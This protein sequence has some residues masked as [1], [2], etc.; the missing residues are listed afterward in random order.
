MGN[1]AP[2][3]PLMDQAQITELLEQSSDILS[4]SN[5]DYKCLLH[6]CVPLSGF[7]PDEAYL[8]RCEA[9]GEYDIPSE[10]TDFEALELELVRRKNCFHLIVTFWLLKRRTSN[11]KRQEI[12]TELNNIL[13]PIGEF[14]SPCSV[15]PPSLLRAVKTHNLRLLSF[16]LCQIVDTFVDISKPIHFMQN[17]TDFNIRRPQLDVIENMVKLT[18][19]LATKKRR[20]ELR[21]EDDIKEDVACCFPE[22]YCRKIGNY[23]QWNLYAENPQVLWDA[24]RAREKIERLQRRSEEK[25]YEEEL[26][27]KEEAKRLAEEKEEADALSEFVKFKETNDP[28]YRERFQQDIHERGRGVEMTSDFDIKYPTVPGAIGNILVKFGAKIEPHLY[29]RPAHLVSAH[30]SCETVVLIRS[31]SHWGFVVVCGKGQV[32]LHGKGDTSLNL[33][34]AVVSFRDH[35][36]NW[37]IVENAEH[38]IV[39][40]MK[41]KRVRFRGQDIHRSIKNKK[42]VV[43]RFLDEDDDKA[44]YE[45]TMASS[46][47]SLQADDLHYNLR[48]GFDFFYKAR[49]FTGLYQHITPSSMEAPYHNAWYRDHNS[50]FYRDQGE[51]SFTQ[52]YQKCDIVDYKGAKYCLQRV[53]FQ[54][55]KATP[56]QTWTLYRN[57]EPFPDGTLQG[58]IADTNCCCIVQKDPFHWDLM[59]G[60]EGLYT[61]WRIE[62]RG[63]VRIDLDSEQVAFVA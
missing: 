34:L 39:I 43:F 18:Q 16:A 8:A 13:K 56:S 44:A 10:K 12:I 37:E 53:K 50:D 31:T 1:K 58:Q 51:F 63:D 54:D 33:K 14:Y 6:L 60:H 3:R 11:A 49:Q 21:Y 23:A 41:D 47:L 29:V 46:Q 45:P 32:I 40:I 9:K 20:M 25:K 5:S 62:R 35:P 42:G 17:H 4:L 36:G 26:K 38:D 30:R 2:Q 55:T 28:H 22:V 15:C 7:S 57:A 61:L 24:Q 59:C 19:I 48:L 27:A 52:E